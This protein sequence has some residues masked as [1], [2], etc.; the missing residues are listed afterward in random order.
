GYEFYQ[1]DPASG[2]VREFDHEISHKGD[3]DDQ[4]WDKFGDLVWD[5]TELIKCLESPDPDQL[6]NPQSPAATIYLAETTSDL[7]EER[8]SVK[9]ELQQ[10]GHLVLPDKALPLKAPALQQ[11][12]REYL[13]CSRL[14]VHLIGEHYGVI[15]EM[16]TERSIVR[17]QQEL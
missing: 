2:K 17:L 1:R 7:S 10:F 8:N 4:Y 12:V 5:I 16:E 6:P 15:P 14:S 11:A 3:K 13:M 9:R